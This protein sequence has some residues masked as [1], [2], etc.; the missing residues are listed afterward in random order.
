MTLVLDSGALLAIARD[1]RPM[2]RRLKAARLAD[3]IPVSHGGVIGQAWRGAGPRQARLAIALRGIEVR[4]LDAQL[5]RKSGEL[6]AASGTRD[7]IDAALVVVAEDGDEI[8]TSDPDD[9]ALLA[10]GAGTHVEIVAI[11]EV[12]R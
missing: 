6:L 9:L 7:V 4:A 3:S 5:G 1:D 10:E 11:L 12:M 2:W 8:I